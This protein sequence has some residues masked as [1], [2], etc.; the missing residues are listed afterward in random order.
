MMYFADLK[1][2]LEGPEV[3]NKIELLSC[4]E[5]LLNGKQLVVEEDGAT[6]YFNLEVLSASVS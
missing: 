2:S 1:V 3:P 6:E 4:M 5:D